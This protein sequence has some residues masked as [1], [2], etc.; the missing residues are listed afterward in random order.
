[1]TRRSW[2]APLAF[3]V[4]CGRKRASRRIVSVAVHPAGQGHVVCGFETGA[5]VWESGAQIQT[6]ARVNDLDFAPD[7]DTLAVAG[8]NLIVCGGNSGASPRVLRDDGRN[9]GT[10]RFFADGRRLLTI[11]GAGTMEVLDAATGRELSRSCCSTIYGEVA[12]LPGEREFVSAGHWPAIWRVGGA[13]GVEARL[14]PKREFMTFGPV[15]VDAARNRAVL[16]S[17]DG[18]VQIWSLA[19]RERTGRFHLVRDGYVDA[20]A[21][22]GRTGTIIGGSMGKPLTAVHPETGGR[23]AIASAPPSSCIRFGADGDTL[24]YGT[25]TGAIERVNVLAFL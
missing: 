12:L 2:L 4:A 14:T 3:S 23:T 21:V 11:T 15:V 18:T 17:Q 8:R 10:V 20:L 1:M 13:G 6:G 16:G 22:H 19:S 9:Y 7:G 5:V 24:V 25:E